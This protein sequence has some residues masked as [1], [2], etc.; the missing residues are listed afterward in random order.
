MLD[1]GMHLGRGASKFPDFSQLAPSG[2]YTG[3]VDCLIISHFHLDHCGALPYFTEKCGFDGPVFMTYPT[4]SIVPALLE[5]FRRVSTFDRDKD[6][7]RDTPSTPTPTPPPPSTAAQ[8]M[9]T[10]EQISA[11]MRKVIPMT[12]RQLIRAPCAR[13]GPPVMVRV[14]YGS[15][16][17]GAG[18]WEVRV[19]SQ[20]IVYTGDYNMT[21][22]RHLGS[23]LA[24]RMLRPDLLITESTYCTLIRGSKRARER[25]FLRRVHETVSKGGKVLLPVFA[26]GRAQEVMLLIDAYWERMELRVP[27]YYSKGLV[28]KANSV[29]TNFISWMNESMKETF[30]QRPLFDFRHITQLDR[31]T[32]NLD[33][34][35]PMVLFATPGMLH[36]GLSLEVFRKWGENEANLVIFPGYCAPGTIGAKVLDGE[37]KIAFESGG[38]MEVRC[39]VTSLSF[40]AHVDAKGII[41]L[42]KTIEPRNVLL[43]HGERYKMCVR[44]FPSSAMD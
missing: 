37:K 34:P 22:D 36:T 23:A 8:E 13:E 18:I 20:C 44:P 16:V 12:T 9:F 26:L 24:P 29:Y 27:V 31:A 14:W 21:A 43:V 38:S 7:R 3:H 30:T 35:G 6:H 11:A 1:C 4:R 40:S 41:Q 2:P 32:M 42:I 39:D 19:G 17:L 10:S 33:S 5:D 25:E 28:T 15:H